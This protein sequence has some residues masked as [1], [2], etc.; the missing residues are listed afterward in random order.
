MGAIDFIERRKELKIR[1]FLFFIAIGTLGVVIGIIGA[2]L[3]AV[4]KSAMV[5]Y[6]ILL[7]LVGA[8]F[9]TFCL[10]FSPDSYDL[11]EGE[12]EYSWA[13]SR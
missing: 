6:F 2:I 11:N 8:I 1:V 10:F 7:F 13:I 5:G 4:W 12:T 3:S 9:F